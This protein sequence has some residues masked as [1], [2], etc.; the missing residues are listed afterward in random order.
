MNASKDLVIG[1]DSSTTATK[2][3]AWDGHGRAIAESRMPIE[4][5]SPQPDWNEQR[6]EDWWSALC[7]VLRDLSARLNASRF[8][9]LCITNQRETFVPVDQEGRSL[10]HAIL[11]L[12]TRSRAEVEA[13]D[14]QIGNDNIHDLTGKGPGTTQS[15]PKLLWLQA[16]EPEVMQRSYKFVE[17]HAYLVYHLTGRW[18]TSLACA[19]P[20]GTVDMRKGQWAADLLGAVGLDVNQFVEIVV[21]GS[22]IG[23]LTSDAARATGLLPG[24]PVIA[25]AGDGQCAGLGANITA[26]GRAYL[27]LGTAMVSGAYASYYVA[28]RAFRT[29]CLPLDGAFVL[30]E[31]LNAGTFLVSWFV[32]NFGPEGSG[33]GSPEDVLE[34]AASKLPPGADGL[35]LVP[36]WKGVQSPY[37][38]TKA[39]GITI[40]WTGAHRKEHFYRAILEGIAYEHRLAM[41]AMEQVSGQPVAEFILM[42]GGSRS[43]LWCQIIADVTGKRATRA[44]TTE[45]SALGAGILAAAAG[46]YA[47]AREAAN[48]MTSTGQSFEPSEATHHVYDRLFT[49]VY[50]G[51]FPIVQPYV[52]RLSELTAQSASTD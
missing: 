6:A 10:R 3:I 22:V 1:V 12:D 30:E 8:A 49:E 44:S 40:G 41:E 31:A 33:L 43:P 28:N 21:P 9:A 26:P 16:H 15:L 51:L 4:M 18:A 2:A 52:D 34:G 29:Q 7:T 42:G 38:D 39:R 48:A 17:P 47:N 23:G 35:L 24:T 27:N 36:Y 32:E 45:A 19:D 11:W 13:L 14:R 25:G 46:W 50:R 37:W 5:F 20:M